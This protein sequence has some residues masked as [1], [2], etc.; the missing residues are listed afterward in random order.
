MPRGGKRKGS[1]RKS[2]WNSTPTKTIKVP[3]LYV[4]EIVRFAR[5]LDE[6]EFSTLSIADLFR[7]AKEKHSITAQVKKSENQLSFEI[8][9]DSKQEKTQELVLSQHKAS[10]PNDP[11]STVDFRPPFTLTKDQKIALESMKQFIFSQQKYF[12]LNGYAGTGKSYLTVQFMKWLRNQKQVFVAGSPTNKAVKNLRKLAEE[13]QVSIEAF[14]VAQLLGQQPELN[15]QT[16][17]EEFVSKGGKSIDGYSVV[18]IDEFSMISKKN[19]EEIHLEIARSKTKVIFVGDAAQLPPVG[20]SEPIIATSNLINSGATLNKIVRYD[21]EIAHIA[22]EIRSQEKFNRRLY[23]FFTTKD[24]TVT[25]LPRAEWLS[26]AISYFQSEAYRENPD[27]VRFIVW[28]NK[29]AAALNDFV[30]EKLWG[31]EAPPYVKGDRLIAKKPVFRPNPGAK[32]KNKW[33]ILMNNSEECEVVGQA[34]IKQ[35]KST[36]WEYWEV[37][38]LTDGGLK[39]PLRIL[40]LE[41][42]NERE[43]RLLGLK[44]LKRWRPYYDLLKSFDNVPYAYAITTHKAQGSSI[45]YIFPD[46]DD[47]RRCPDLQKIL[48]TA[49]TRATK[50]AFIPSCN[51]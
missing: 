12:R 27:Y 32:G 39:L 2:T 50:R 51:I 35:D 28:R 29:T 48:Y 22:E 30:R 24:E 37:P 17:K 40:T 46:I 43:K 38:V 26:L 36:S 45:D 33:R 8:D 6:G 20:E 16:G 21:G 41:C 31:I 15:E 14:T 7:S 5:M 42:E 19:F 11:K 10:N 1:G 47:M 44:E 3:E 34:E 23:P 25:C 4:E 13:S 18:L 49:L 9:G